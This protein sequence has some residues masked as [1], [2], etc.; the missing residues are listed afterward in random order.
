MSRKRKS[1]SHSM[2][3]ALESTHTLYD[4]L[5]TVE[6]RPEFWCVNVTVKPVDQ[7][8]KINGTLGKNAAATIEVNI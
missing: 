4:S 8:Y 2:S 6:G 7:N 5:R 1:Q 3:S